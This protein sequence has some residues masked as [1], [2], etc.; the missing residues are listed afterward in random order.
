MLAVF[1]DVFYGNLY[2]KAWGFWCH[3]RKNEIAPREVKRWELAI[4]LRIATLFV[5]SCEPRI[6]EGGKTD[7]DA[8]TEIEKLMEWPLE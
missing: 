3:L 5:Y 8:F 6:W 2:S 1:Q 7:D 4:R